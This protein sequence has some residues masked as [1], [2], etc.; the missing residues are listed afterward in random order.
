[1]TRR[2]RRLGIGIARCANIYREQLEAG[3]A[4]PSGTPSRFTD[5]PRPICFGVLGRCGSKQTPIALTHAVM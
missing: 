3:A 5:L 2:R 4:N 1:M